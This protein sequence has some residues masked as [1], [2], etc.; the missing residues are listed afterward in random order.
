MPVILQN[1]DLRFCVISWL[2][3]KMWFYLE[4]LPAVFLMCSIVLYILRDYVK[5]CPRKNFK[6][7]FLF[8]IWE[9]HTLRKVCVESVASYQGCPYFKSFFSWFCMVYNKRKHVD[10]I[11]ILK[12]FHWNLSPPCTELVVVISFYT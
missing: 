1:L 12:H 9:T 8:E 7:S 2:R 11:N 6:V 3:F 4:L 5:H 10:L